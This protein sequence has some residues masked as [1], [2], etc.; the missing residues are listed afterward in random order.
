M[1]MALPITNLCLILIAQFSVTTRIRANLLL[2]ILAWDYR[3]PYSGSLQRYY[4]TQLMESHTVKHQRAD[5]VCFRRRAQHMPPY[6][7]TLLSSSST[8]M[9]HRVQF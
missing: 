5:I 2:T 6:G 9:N 4:R 3:A 7:S 8:R 1:R